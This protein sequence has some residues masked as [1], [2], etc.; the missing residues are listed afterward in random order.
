MK[1]TEWSLFA[2]IDRFD[3]A[4]LSASWEEDPFVFSYYEDVYGSLT[5]SSD[6]QT[7]FLIGYEQGADF[8]AKEASEHTDRYDGLV[9][10]G[11]N[12]IEK[13]ILQGSTEQEE[14]IPLSVWIINT[15]KTS[16]D[17][18][19]LSYWK[20]RNQI[21]GSSLQSWKCRFADELFLP[22]ASSADGID[23]EIS[24]MGIVVF[25]REEEYRT[26]FVSGKIARNFISTV[27]RD[28][29]CFR[30]PV[31]GGEITEIHDP[32]FTYN[33]MEYQ[34]QQRD[35]W[36]YVPDQKR[37]TDQPFSLILCLHGSGG[38]GEDMI[39]RSGWHE[40]AAEMNS[41]ILYPSS[42]YRNGYQ[43]YWQNIPEEISFIRYLVERVCSLYPVDPS[44]IYVTG[45]SNGAGMAQ[46]LV[47]RCSDLFAAAALSAP[48]YFDEEY[49]GP[50]D[51]ESL[52]EAAI[53]FS[54]GED[55][56]YLKYFNNT[57][58]IDDIPAIRHLEFWRR[59][60]GFNQ[61]DYQY[62]K[63]GKFRIYTY[64][65]KNMLPVCQWIVVDEK[66]HSY[67]KEEVPIYFDF[68]RHYTRGTEGKL[69]YDGT[70]V[71]SDSHTGRP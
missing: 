51:P 25:S 65:S 31:T 8:A 10:L 39:F 18:K 48:V 6:Y 1:K 2:Q 53:L 45:Y 22:A 19:N 37:K 68:L 23:P 4:L 71:I 9:T 49:Y 55:D 44:R 28:S 67:P 47:I 69:Y 15:G 70:Q 41:I 7:M 43:H 13:D 32:G 36:I 5:E 12:G 14:E 59:F 57:A 46:N 24:R 3:I 20:A 63:K 17:T 21:K 66:E 54:Y 52:N 27:T 58:E 16:S 50:L 29:V 61:E 56:P 42:L 26:H 62:D 35:C 34:G 60:Y 11:G 33:R 38:N 30:D 40:N 64:Q